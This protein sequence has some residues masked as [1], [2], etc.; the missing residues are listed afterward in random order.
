MR[1]IILDT[2]GNAVPEDLLLVGV[3]GF[4]FRDGSYFYVVVIQ[5]FVEG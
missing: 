2:I 3:V 1:G 4:G 5:V